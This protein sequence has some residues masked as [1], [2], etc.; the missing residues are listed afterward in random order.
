MPQRRR[1]RREYMRRYMRGYMA[2]RRA[3]AREYGDQ[4]GDCLPS[5]DLG[6][7]RARGGGYNISSASNGLLYPSPTALASRRI[8]GCNGQQV[9]RYMAYAHAH[10]WTIAEGVHPYGG[11]PVYFAVRQYQ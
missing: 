11:G 10:G 4:D 6:Q 3:L 5:P 1:D 8:Y 2:R 7:G 9:L